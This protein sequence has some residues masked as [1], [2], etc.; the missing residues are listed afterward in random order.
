MIALAPRERG[1]W[2]RGAGIAVGLILVAAP[3]LLLLRTLAWPT[4]VAPLGG[5]F[6]AAIGRSLG[7]AAGAAG[8]AL[9]LGFPSGLVAGLYRFPMRRLLLAALAVPL[10]I[11]SFLWAIGLSI[12]RI[13]IGLPRDSILS[14]AGGT[15]LAFAALGIP[16]VAF[17]TLVAIRFLPANALDA[18]RIAGGELA[19][20]RNVSRA[21]VPAALAA[22][23][24]AGLVSIADPGPG[25]I[26]GFSGAATHVLISF[27]ALYDF[28]LAARQ[29]LIAAAVA[30]VAAAP[31]ILMI[32]R[33]S[34]V[35]LLPRETRLAPPRAQPVAAW[36]SPLVLAGALTITLL[37]PLT[38]L[39]APLVKTFEF[40][41]VLTAVSRTGASTLLYALGAGVV[42]TV[43]AL[44][45]AL[46]AVRSAKLRTAVLGSLILVAVLP[47]AVGALG[48][49]QLAGEAP[50]WLD[51]FLRSRFTVAAV[52]GL[53][54][55]A[56]AA[57]VLMRALGSAS[58][59]WAA[60]AAV[61][62]VPPLTYARRV[63]A[64]FFAGPV[65]MSIGLVALLAGADV[66]T[67]LLLAPPG[68]DSLALAIFT[69]MANAPESVVASLCLAYVSLGGVIV[70][71]L[72]VA[73]GVRNS[74]ARRA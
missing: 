28:E 65:F 6:L 38:G 12:F 9:A 36:V 15:I 4:G 1:S 64:P 19:V 45:L 41:S 25:Q 48:V 34:S 30:L 31:L 74:G 20:A 27:S 40:D 58:P 55:T 11:P 10:L 72:A 16:L 63:L 39:V 29:G 57:I 37:A 43:C 51:P 67:V 61:H 21:V 66:T 8:V 46:S 73:F 60:A 32:A 70:A 3:A 50:P 49:V 2:W 23:L 18:A 44:P 47:P 69:V 33:H 59:S 54:L 22:A 17:T 68:R 62:G 35:A 56:I 71:A 42:A 13:E 53:R 7:V 26:L 14:G 5:G 24:V 52:I